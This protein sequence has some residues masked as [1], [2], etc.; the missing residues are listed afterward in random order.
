MKGLED[1][2]SEVWIVF[3]ENFVYLDRICGHEEGIAR[4]ISLHNELDSCC[5][6]L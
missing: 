1:V 5:K 2:T 6:L 4:C 3:K